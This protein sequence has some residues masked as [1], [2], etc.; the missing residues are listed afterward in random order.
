M[1]TAFDEADVKYQL[2]PSYVYRQNTEERAIR[3]L[4]PHI[5][6]ALYLYDTT[7]SIQRMGSTYSPA[8]NPEPTKIIKT[9]SFLISV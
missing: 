7:L 5:T 9:E 8:T 2:L 1:N 6:T 4:K 3:T